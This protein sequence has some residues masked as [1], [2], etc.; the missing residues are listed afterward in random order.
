MP[1]R[2]ARG[3]RGR[4]RMP[5]GASGG[6]DA[7]GSGG[8]R[9][10]VVEMSRGASLPFGVR[11]RA[12][13]VELRARDP[14]LVECGGHERPRDPDVGEPFEVLPPAYSA[15]R[16]ERELRELTPDTVHEDE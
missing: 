7:P 8:G 2:T 3:A 12:E 14:A 9:R 13:R 4:S 10:G 1:S 5:P 11:P 16:D 6:P 15:A